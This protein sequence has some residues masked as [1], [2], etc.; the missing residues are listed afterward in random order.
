MIKIA[1]QSCPK[2]SWDWTHKN[3][4]LSKVEQ[5]TL[6]IV[7]IWKLSSKCDIVFMAYQQIGVYL[8]QKHIF[9]CKSFFVFWTDIACD[10]RLYLYSVLGIEVVYAIFGQIM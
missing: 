1:Q 10:P 9:N 2:E 7:F 6:K 3:G 4:T 8:R 5:K